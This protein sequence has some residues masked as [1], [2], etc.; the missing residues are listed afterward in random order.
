VSASDF[1]SVSVSLSNA[2]GPTRAALNVGMVLAYHT[3]YTARQKLYSS[4]TML[5]QMV[6]DGFSVNSAAYKCAAKYLSAPN[7]PASCVIGRRA[8]PPLQHLQ[9]T[10]TD[11]AVGDAYAFTL[12]GSDGVT[13]SLAYSNVANPGPAIPGTALSGT[14]TVTNGSTSV[15]FSA[16]QTLSAGTL[17]TFSSQAG[18]SYAVATATTA[19]TSAT[20]TS[21]YTGASSSSAT[22]TPGA[23][24]LVTNGSATVT[25]SVAQTLSKGAQLT[26][27]SQ[28]NTVYILSAAIVAATSG[29]LTVAYSGTGAS[30]TNTQALAPLSG[31]FNVSNG[32]ASVATTS[33]Q[34]GVVAVGDTLEFSAQPGVPYVVF[35]VSATTIVLTSAYTGTSAAT[36]NACD[37]CTASTAATVLSATMASMTNIGTPSVAG[38][39]ITLQRTD[40][41]LTDV[42]DWISNGFGNIELQDLTADPGVV[43]DFLAVKAANP[44]SFYAVMLD[45]NSA[46][47][48]EALASTIE[49][50][51]NGG[52]IFFANNSDW[53]NW[54][55]TVTNDLNSVLQLQS[56]KRTLVGQNNSQLLCYEGA[57]VCGLALGQNPGSYT[58]AEKS[59][60]GVPADTDTTLPEGGALVLNTMTAANPGSGGKGG[61]YY[62]TVS[63]LN[64]FF[65]GVTPGGQFLDITISIDW[66]VVNIQADVLAVLASLPKVPFTDAGISVIQ[67][68]IDRRL[69][70]GSTATYG[71]IVPDGSDP[72]RPI[73][74]T[75]PTAASLTSTQR[76]TRN[77]SG[78][79]WSAGLQGAIQT[80]TIQGTL[81]P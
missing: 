7:V 31:T 3:V 39:V 14:A 58:V 51:G 41:N 18:V 68:A 74:V 45:S 48:I 64:W 78:V 79:S 81:T 60:A 17:L 6:T 9:L 24:S 46:A 36:A 8:L 34:V 22:T 32:S 10:C 27:A 59:L 43:A 67:T 56:Y 40:G 11:G 71:M 26:F 38:A 50:T 15:T 62:K 69:R 53:G 75:V 1:V 23:T 25:F 33:S 61:N 66:L 52:N 37:V 13:H 35:S 20:L 54:Q 47:E 16:S 72:T 65:P 77:L 29:T 73:V 80:V 70:I 2:Q 30:A 12:V 19:S 49:A 28:P 42:Q 44:Q 5:S 4:A 63:G 76:Q 57:A 21:I 55:S